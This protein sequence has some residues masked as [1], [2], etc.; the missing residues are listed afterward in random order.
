M[1]RS[2]SSL[3]A[4]REEKGWGDAFAEDV[5]KKIAELSKDREVVSVSITPLVHS[6]EIFDMRASAMTPTPEA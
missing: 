2:S 3:V 1:I 6:R 4:R 5:D